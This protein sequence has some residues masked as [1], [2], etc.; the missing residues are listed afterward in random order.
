[1]GRSKVRGTKMAVVAELR[2]VTELHSRTGQQHLN[3]EHLV[4]SEEEE[5]SNYGTPK[6]AE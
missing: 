3:S 6:M 4:K 2:S 1:M 5:T